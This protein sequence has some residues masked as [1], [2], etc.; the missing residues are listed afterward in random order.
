MENE[1]QILNNID[2]N[3]TSTQREIA[4]KSGMSLGSVNVLIKRLVK[5]GMLKI[6]RLN[7]KTIR[8]ILT[9]EGMKEKTEATYRYIL[10]SYKYINEVDQKIYLLFQRENIR[11]A[12]YIYLFGEQ[13]EIFR[14]LQNKIGLTNNN[15][16]VASSYEELKNIIEMNDSI[17]KPIDN[18]KESV[19]LVWHPD[20]YSILCD[21]KKTIINVLDNL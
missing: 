11:E 10:N 21:S 1:L 6:E 9:P 16:F 2:S 18:K 20:Y 19:I 14:L 13:D 12:D 5:K 17:V 7:A 15:Y 8:Y 3:N 4:K